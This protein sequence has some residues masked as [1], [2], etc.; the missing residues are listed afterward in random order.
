MSWESRITQLCNDSALFAK[1]YNNEEGH[2]ALEWLYVY[3][4][5]TEYQ[6]NAIRSQIESKLYNLEDEIKEYLKNIKHGVE[7]QAEKGH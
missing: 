4:V 2:D 1:I 5:I 7:F 6:Y 3:D